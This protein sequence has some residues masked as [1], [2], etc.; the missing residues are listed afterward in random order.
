MPERK[1]FFFRWG[2]PKASR[3]VYATTITNSKSF[4]CYLKNL[5]LNLK[6]NKHCQDVLVV[7]QMSLV[8]IL[9]SLRLVCFLDSNTLV[10]IIINNWFVHA[11]HE[12]VTRLV[13]TFELRINNFCR[14]Q[15][16]QSGSNWEFGQKNVFQNWSEMARKL[17]KSIFWHQDPTSFGRGVWGS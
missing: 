10:L 2:L 4:N 11:I 9:L 6:S 15:S 1:R 7:L 3:V 5:N 12:S 16:I 17:V 13:A 14:N 8:G